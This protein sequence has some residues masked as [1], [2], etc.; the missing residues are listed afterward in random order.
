M[1]WRRLTTL[2]CAAVL[3]VAAVAAP[4]ANDAGAPLPD[5]P[6][7]AST[8]LRAAEDARAAGQGDAAA[9]RAGLAH[10]D[11]SLR[12]QAARAVGR[13]EDPAWLPSLAPLLDDP[14][15][16]VRG[17]AAWA[18]A[19]SVAGEPDPA[20][21]GQVWRTAEA[22][23]RQRLD[24]D[25]DG[26]VRG[27]L[28]A[29]LARL[30]FDTSEDL[31]GIADRLAA[32]IPAAT[33]EGAAPAAPTSVRVGTARGAHALARRCAVR[34]A[35]C[36]RVHA[37]LIHLLD[38]HGAESAGLAPA[39]AA[40][41][42][43]LAALGLVALPAP[44][45]T[46]EI[47]ERLRA[48]ADAE[49]RRAAA[50]ATTTLDALPE[51]AAE[52]LATD[53]A[54]VVRATFLARAGARWPALAR[55]ARRDPDAHVRLAAIDALGA[56]GA[57][58]CADLLRGGEIDASA[59]PTADTRSDD[60]GWQA[61]AHALVAA[62]RSQP[63][64]ARVPVAR[65]S[66]SG[67][68]QVRI[69]AARAAAVL[70]DVAT[71]RTL[72]RDMH[73]N[74]REAALAGLDALR[75]RA[76]DDL[77]R[78]A[79]ESGDYQLVL[80]AARGLEGTPAPGLAADALLA[81]LR[82]LTDDA[83]DTSRDPRLALLERLGDV[84]PDDRLPA[85]EQWLRDA[86]RVVAHRAAALLTT[87]TGRRVAAAP[88]PRPSSLP[89]PTPDAIERLA[90]RQVVLTL[91]GLG[92]VVVRL[93]AVDAPMNAGR[94]VRQVEQ[95]D[96]DGLTFHRVEPGF[97]V[98]GGSPGANEYVGAD[99]YTRDERSPLSHVRGTV[100]ISTRGRDTGDG[101]IFVN[102]VDNPRLDHA[103]TIIGQV[104]AGMAH[105]DAMHEGAVIAR[106]RVVGER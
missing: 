22:M 9:L 69:Y 41:I 74:V 15:I 2:V 39:V 4:Q 83:R 47:L 53:P 102:L 5:S 99:A 62:A 90:T 80:T 46:V 98:Q 64:A 48:D 13:L 25:T 12:L 20:T 35:A 92:D 104:V 67:T 81:A 106:A 65:A 88:Q 105:V 51:R 87:R 94:F 66:R 85:L 10:A 6:S 50:V 68:W 73:P 29:N 1:A 78:E 8:R 63:D 3:G 58:D 71:L 101:Q 60:D 89:V 70:E 27:A 86:D 36:P 82:R 14:S 91:H 45:P 16:D 19:Q 43:R 52:A 97:V 34:K 11:V 93:F 100:G 37:L 30:P 96:W 31:D 28:A 32:L 18:V 79:L 49:V 17:E 26:L 7:A 95:G 23:L 75:H 56:A 55:S 40:R 21:A 24:K 42:R 76:S 77:R 103:Y 54:P 33:I 84:L 57:C 38:Q 44:A 61:F 72:A 59:T